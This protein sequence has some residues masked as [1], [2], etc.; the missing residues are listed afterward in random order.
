MGKSITGAKIN[1]SGGS[2]TITGVS[3]SEARLE[4]FITPNNNQDFSKDEIQ[5]RLDEYYTLT[6]SVDNNKLIASVKQKHA[7]N[8]N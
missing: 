1:A 2:I 4:V 3:E 7:M 8:M 5:Q 6:I